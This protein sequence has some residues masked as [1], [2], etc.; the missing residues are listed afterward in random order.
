MKK[1][2]SLMMML[3]MMAAA[4]GFTACG[5]S[6]DSDDEGGGDTS[7]L[8]GTWEIVQDVTYFEGKPKYYECYGAYWVFTNNTITIHDKEDL[9]DGQ[10]VNYTLRGDKLVVAGMESDT[11]VELTSTTLVLRTVEIMNSYTILTFK[12]R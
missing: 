11:V 6:S 9:M 12:K 5:S 8:V 7:M 4:L 3:A 2:Y 10:T 1:I